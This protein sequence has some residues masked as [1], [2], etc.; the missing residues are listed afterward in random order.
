MK[1]LLDRL[2]FHLTHDEEHDHMMSFSCRSCSANMEWR[3]LEH[4]RQGSSCY[5]HQP[6]AFARNLIT[7]RKTSKRKSSSSMARFFDHD[8][9]PWS[10]SLPARLCPMI[11]FHSI[12][13]RRNIIA[14]DQTCKSCWRWWLMINCW[15]VELCR[16]QEQIHSQRNKERKYGSTSSL[17]CVNVDHLSH[18]DDCKFIIFV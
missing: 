17:E 8:F 14:G 15:N 18:H 4:G 13:V 7:D 12:V 10:T 9:N 3:R 5:L 6:F 2:S 11:E 16:L 1:F